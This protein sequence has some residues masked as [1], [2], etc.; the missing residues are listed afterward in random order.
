MHLSLAGFNQIRIRAHVGAP[1]QL[2]IILA[3]TSA[4]A[5][6][7]KKVASKSPEG[8]NRLNSMAAP[9]YGYFNS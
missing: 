5:L 7:S 1:L 9:A 2:L 3:K 8:Q 6:N 4:I